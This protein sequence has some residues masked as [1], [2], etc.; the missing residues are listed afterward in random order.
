MELADRFEVALLQLKS[1]MGV[2]CPQ[3]FSNPVP[4]VPTVVLETPQKFDAFLWRRCDGHVDASWSHCYEHC[5][6]NPNV[7]NI[8]RSIHFKI[9]NLPSFFCVQR[10]SWQHILCFHFQHK[11]RNTQ[12]NIPLPPGEQSHVIKLQGGQGCGGWGA[13]PTR[14][15]RLAKIFYDQKFCDPLCFYYYAFLASLTSD[16][17][18]QHSAS[19][20][21]SITVVCKPCEYYVSLWQVFLP[22]MCINLVVI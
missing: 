11:L 9:L 6:P 19:G 2:H 5:C 16:F 4:R 12:K 14:G 22:F 21:R 17:M 18:R 13:P 8:I 1:Q 20:T 7:Y 10:S 3:M 15:P